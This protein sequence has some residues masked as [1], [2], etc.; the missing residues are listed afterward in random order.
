MAFDPA[1]NAM[2]MASAGI[3]MPLEVSNEI[4]S[5][6][7]EESAIMRL[8]TPIDLPSN[9]L[10]ID[11]ISGDPEAFWVDNDTDEVQVS[12]PSATNKKMAGYTMAV[13]VPFS[14]KFAED[15]ARLYDE[16]VARVPLAMAGKFDGTC[17]GKYDKPGELFD[18]FTV[19]PAVDIATDPWAGLVAADTMIAEQNA[20]LNGYAYSPKMRSILL[21]AKDG[22]NRPLFVN[23]VAS[24][25]V[26]MLL[27]SPT[28][29]N[30]N[31]YV[32]GTPNT[33][34]VAGDWTSARYG[35]VRNMRIT[36]ATQATLNIG[37]EQVNL[38]QRRMF[39]L[40][41]EFEIGFRFKYENDFVRLTDKA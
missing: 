10:Q 37:G 14:N 24:E 3:E 26:P 12:T 41:F 39:A 9:G 19:C 38:F 40:M 17:M 33:L 29:M 20:V 22:D 2:T 7:Q 27:G 4:W 36:P 28:Y 6:V 15:K 8:A 21:N 13:I 23:G 30:R 25:A 11:M 32:E 34:G 35:F 18:Q 5:K 16:M 1:T 31:L